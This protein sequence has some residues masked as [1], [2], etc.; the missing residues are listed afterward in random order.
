LGEFIF[1]KKHLKNYTEAF[2]I[3]AMP[4]RFTPFQILDILILGPYLGIV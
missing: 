4:P 3:M 1:A 2:K